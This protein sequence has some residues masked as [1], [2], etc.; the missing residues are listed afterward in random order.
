MHVSEIDTANKLPFD[1][2]Q[3]NTTSSWFPSLHII[4]KMWQKWL[5]FEIQNQSR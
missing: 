3:Q 4:K 5:Y 2:Y 1:F